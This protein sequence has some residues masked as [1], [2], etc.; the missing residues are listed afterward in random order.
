VSGDIRYDNDL[1]NQF[2]T[3][4]PPYIGFTDP[5]VN[6]RSIAAKGDMNAYYPQPALRIDDLDAP[7]AAAPAPHAA[8]SDSG[9]ESDG[10]GF[11]LLRRGREEL[12]RP[13]HE[14]PRGESRIRHAP[15]LTRDME[16][17]GAEGDRANRDQTHRSG[18]EHERSRRE[19]AHHRPRGPSDLAF[20]L[21]VLDHEFEHVFSLLNH[22]FGSLYDMDHKLEAARN[23]PVLIRA[24]DDTLAK[25]DYYRRIL[26]M[27]WYA[28]T[29]EFHG[30]LTAAQDDFHRTA[31]GSYP[32]P[33]VDITSPTEVTVTAVT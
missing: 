32:R 19:R 2:A 3:N 30:R 20:R 9:D 28:A 26:G 13:D 5:Q 29:S 6:N 1:A 15:S 31:A 17:D 23:Q 27:T 12:S 11:R 21:H 25:G 16:H 8:A 18:F 10:D 22:V 4:D 7:A 33:R 24:D 14:R